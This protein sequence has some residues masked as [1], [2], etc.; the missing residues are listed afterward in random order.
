MLAQRVRE[1][2]CGDKQRKVARAPR[3]ERRAA[4]RRAPGRGGDNQ[5]VPVRPE[6]E[7]APLLTAKKPLTARETPTRKHAPS[8]QRHGLHRRRHR[9]APAR[10]HACSRA[11]RARSAGSCVRAPHASCPSV[12][13]RGAS[14]STC[15]RKAARMRALGTA[16][17]GVRRARPA[18]TLLRWRAGVRRSGLP[19]QTAQGGS[20][21]AVLRRGGGPFQP[22][23]AHALDPAREAEERAE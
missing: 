14:K 8:T 12:K 4:R 21:G 3:D 15:R 5:R 7:G 10:Q 22:R 17:G 13:T 1:E 23:L 9:L 19:R 18:S 20:C 16:G 11:Q 6:A 2:A